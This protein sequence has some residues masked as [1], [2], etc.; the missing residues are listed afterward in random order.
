MPVGARGHADGVRGLEHVAVLEPADLKAGQDRREREQYKP[1]LA[2]RINCV[3]CSLPR[4]S[5]RCCHVFPKTI[6]DRT[7]SLLHVQLSINEKRAYVTILRKH[8]LCGSGDGRTYVQQ[9][10]RQPRGRLRHDISTRCWGFLFPG[11]HTCALS[12][13]IISNT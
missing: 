4:G 10:P 3:K 1:L 7:N 9:Q 6:W 8:H 5:I 13:R 12:D 2:M 11:T